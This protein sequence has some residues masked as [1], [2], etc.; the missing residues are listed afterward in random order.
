MTGELTGDEALTLASTARAEQALK[1]F[2]AVDEAVRRKAAKPVLALWKQHWAASFSASANRPKPPKIRDEEA[3]RI[4]ML[5][6]ATPSE[7]KPYH[8]HILPQRLDL[9][10]TVRALK[11]GWIDRYVADLIETSAHFVAR[12]APLWRAGLCTR[13]ESDSLILGYYAHGSGARL[14]QEEPL[15]ATKDIW[16]FFEVEGG[17]DLSLAAVDKYTAAEHQWGTLIVR[18]CRS[19]RLD[20]ARLLDASLSALE[21]DFG[22]FRAGWYSRLHTALDPTLE[23][24]AGRAGTYLRLLASP[25]PPTVSFA[26]NAL[27]KL[28]KAGKLDEG[29]LLAEI[30][31]ALQA[32][33]KTAAKDALQLVAAVAKRSPAR[34]AEAGRLAA[35][36]LINEAVDVQKRALDTVEQLGVVDDAEVAATLSAHGDAVL[37]S[38]QPRLRAMTGESQP[39]PE[40]APQPQAPLAPP[41]PAAPDPVAPAGSTD[42]AI[43]LFLE[44]LETCRD[45]IAVER[46]VDGIARFGT[47]AREHETK[48]SPVAKRARQLLNRAVECE[49]QLG[50]AALGAAWVEGGDIEAALSRHLPQRHHRGISK[51]TVTAVFHRRNDDICALLSEGHAGPMLSAP[52]DRSGSVAPGAL[53]DRMLACRA[54][55]RALPVQ[56]L[57]LALMRLRP[58]GRAAALARL[59][60]QDETERAVAYALRAPVKPEGRAVPWVAAWAA[61][62]PGTAAPEI[63]KLVGREIAGAGVPARLGLRISRDTHD[64]Y[65]WCVVQLDVQPTPTEANTRFAS[66]LFH[67]P[68]HN[69]HSQPHPC[70][71]TFEDIAWASTVWPGNSE[72]FFAGAIATLDTYQKLTDHHCLAFLEPLFI[73]GA[74]CGPMGQAMLGFYLA[75]EDRSIT[76]MTVDAITHLVAAGRLSADAFAAQTWP[77]VSVGPLPLSRWV[78]AFREIATASPGHAA[79]VCGAMA[80]LLRFPPDQ[81]PRDLGAMLELLYEL[82]YASGTRLEDPDAQA[83]LRGVKGSGKAGKYAR[84]LLEERTQ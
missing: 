33:Q 83:C 46:A 64:Q 57:A 49:T 5:A 24:M 19:G 74:P 31:P 21:R 62:S 60:P 58:D 38:L 81:I 10:E 69:V 26:L 52:T 23:E 37:P 8:F 48:L 75:S 11:P 13:P 42:E 27:K 16:R 79:F 47:A 61:R 59:D 67:L 22:Q 39:A 63:V 30:A 2:S 50:L 54:A 80:G 55:R 7:L 82:H 14:A 56:D 9:V 29:A 51:G 28:D 18:M 45:P 3:L 78:R 76:G 65:A 72:P 41:E 25:V 32:R 1:R 44:A 36:A 68:I 70:G 84:K 15:F 35:T 4:A 12:V 73:P 34:A 71:T 6:T 40:P 77:F 43:A 20:R 66:S 17:G 53:V